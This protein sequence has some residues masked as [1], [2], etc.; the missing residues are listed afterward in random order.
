MVAPRHLFLQQGKTASSIEIGRMLDKNNCTNIMTKPIDE[1]LSVEHRV[2]VWRV[3][4]QVI[5][6]LRKGS[7]I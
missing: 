7:D 3:G 4:S 2:R 5:D 1:T 6:E